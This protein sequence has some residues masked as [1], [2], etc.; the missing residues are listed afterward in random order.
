MWHGWHTLLCTSSRIRVGAGRCISSADPRRLRQLLLRSTHVRRREAPAAYEEEVV[1]AP[2]DAGLFAR[3]RRCASA[4]QHRE[5][6]EPDYASCFDFT[7]AASSFVL[8]GVADV[9]EA[10]LCPY[11]SY[12]G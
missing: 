3:R 9:P 12:S 2:G 7:G 5:I 4:G 6:Q 8:G 11:G 10:G 1:A